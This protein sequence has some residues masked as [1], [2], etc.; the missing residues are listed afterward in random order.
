MTVKLHTINHRPE[1]M[2]IPKIINSNCDREM[3]N[4]LAD[5]G[6]NSN[7]KSKM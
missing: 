4:Q 6:Y 5:S 1:D 3:K 2:L 7:S